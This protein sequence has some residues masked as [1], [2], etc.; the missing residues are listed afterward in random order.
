MSKAIER[1]QELVNQIAEEIKA[2]SSI[3]IADYRGLNVAQVT[4]LRNKMRAEGLTFKVYK[5]S[6]VRRAMEQNGIEGLEEVLTGPNA[7]AFST[8][9]VVAPARVLNDFAKE[10]EALELKAGVIEGKVAS[11][12]EVKA[13]ATLPNKEGLLSMLLSVL[14]A[15]MRNTALAVKAVADQ[16]AEQEA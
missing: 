16:K 8:E 5:N 6:L 9:D 3:V 13:I 7:I 4:E 15:P 12:E 2:S 11:L 10:N 14:T 1:K